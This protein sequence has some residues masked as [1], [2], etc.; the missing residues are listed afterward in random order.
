LPFEDTTIPVP[1]AYNMVLS[2]RY[3]NYCE[4]RKVWSGH[5]YPFFEAQ[6]ADMEQISGESF[7]RF[8]FD[9][10]MLERP[11][12]D[13]SNSLRTISKECLKE[14]QALLNDA[15]NLLPEIAT[16]IQADDTQDIQDTQVENAQYKTSDRKP[17]NLPEEFTQLISDS[18]QLAADLGTL[19]EQVK[20]E[21]R[22]CTKRVIEVLQGYCDALWMEYQE[23]SGERRKERRKDE[24]DS[25]GSSA[26]NKRL[27]KSR[28]ALELV[29]DRV[30]KDILERR[31]VL[32]LPTGGKEWKSLQPYC[33]KMSAIANTDIYVVPLPLMRKTV[34]GEIRMTDEEIQGAVHLEDYPGSIASSYMDWMKY[35]LSLHCPDMV[36]IQNPYDETNPVLTVPPIFYAANIR[37][38]ADKV[39]YI[40]ALRTAEFGKEDKTDQYNLKHYVTAPGIIFSDEILLWSKNIKEQYVNALTSF[41]GEDTRDIWQDRIKLDTDQAD[42]KCVVPEKEKK[43]LYCI[44]ASELTEHKGILMAAVD[45]RLEIFGNA[46]KSLRLTIA[47]YPGDRKCWDELD[48]ELSGKLFELLDRDAVDGNA[49]VKYNMLTFTPKD[50][51]DVATSFDAYYGSPSPFVP[52]LTT[53]KKPVMLANYDI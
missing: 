43:M 6:K 22:D 11:E 13:K 5:N 2:R 45:S 52:A 32:F 42:I 37:R 3:G 26:S 50:A 17:E 44:G 33:D 39:I 38:Y 4:I 31:E 30:K 21:E 1:A 35:D 16:S 48:P 14:L 49:N 9:R 36:Y 8:S 23:L 15:E 40:S 28:K 34:L 7:D 47:L 46:G 18:Q 53:K 24:T 51:E 25:L 10:S 29:E 41:A 19:I 27:P 20:G 12:P